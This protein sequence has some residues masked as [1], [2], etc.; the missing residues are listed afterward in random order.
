MSILRFFINF[1]AWRTKNFFPGACGGCISPPPPPTAGSIPCQTL[2]ATRPGQLSIHNEVHY[3]L[4]HCAHYPKSEGLGNMQFEEFCYSH[5][6]SFP[7]G[8]NNKLPKR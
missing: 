5:Q 6:T 7:K 8:A 3:N 2:L 1:V 4:T